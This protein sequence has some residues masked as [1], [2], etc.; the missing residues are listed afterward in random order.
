[1][2]FIVSFGLWGTDPK[3]YVGATK[4]LQFLKQHRP[5]WEVHFYYRTDNVIISTIEFLK[6][7]GAYTFDVTNET[8][9][10]APSNEHSMFWRYTPFFDSNNIAI[11]RDL[12]SR[13]SQRELNY[14]DKWLASGTSYFIIRDHPWHS[15]VP[16]GLV[17]MKG[18]ASFKLDCKNY[19]ENNNISYGKDQEFLAEHFSRIHAN[20]IYYCGYDDK[21]NYIPRD[22]KGFFIGMQ[23][24]E[25]DLPT[26]PSATVSLKFLSELGL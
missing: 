12:D 3:Y 7:N 8:Y 1:M 13:F 11:A 22:N 6:T 2:K 15:P 18:N 14:I 19:V 21:T 10:S 20:Q 26:V 25:N 5:E 17:G 16:G 9:T 23:V 24:D 4:N